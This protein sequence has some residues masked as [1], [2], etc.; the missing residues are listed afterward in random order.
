MIALTCVHQSIH[1]VL[2]AFQIFYLIILS[3]KLDFVFVA[4][5]NINTH[6][7]EVYL[8]LDIR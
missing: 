8:G 7:I 2:M 6:L 1:C 3:L 4:V 5:Y